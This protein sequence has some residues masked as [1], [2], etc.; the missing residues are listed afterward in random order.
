MST[1]LILSLR[2]TVNIFIGLVDYRDFITNKELDYL[3]HVS[4][5]HSTT[6]RNADGGDT[7][8][9]LVIRDQ[10]TS[11]SYGRKRPSCQSEITNE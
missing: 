3:Y 4:N 7:S 9:K 10:S 5:N 8:T 11:K 6:G 2:V 1:R